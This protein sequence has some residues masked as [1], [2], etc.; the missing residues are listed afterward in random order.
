MADTVDRYQNGRRYLEKYGLVDDKVT[1]LNLFLQGHRVG[2]KG[3]HEIATGLIDNFSLTSLELRKQEIGKEGAVSIA[4]AL[5]QNRYLRYLGLGRNRIQS[6]GCIILMQ[7][8]CRNQAL[9][10]L[11]L[12]WNDIRDDG[13]IAIGEMLQTNNVLQSFILERNKIKAKGAQHIANGLK[14]NHKLM[15]LNLGYNKVTTSGAAALAG[16]LRENEHL[17]SLNLYMNDIRQEGGVAIAEAVRWNPGL[18]SLNLQGNPLE[19]AAVTF[20]SVLKYNSTL[21]ELNFQ[22][23]GLDTD[24]C[25]QMSEGLLNNQT[26]MSL[27]VAGNPIRNRGFKALLAALKGKTSLRFV[28]LSECGLEGLEAAEDLCELVDLGVNLQVLQLADNKLCREGIMLLCTRMERALA[29]HSLNLDR[30]NMQREGAIALAMA[31][32]QKNYWLSLSVVGNR[33]GVDATKKLLGPLASLTTLTELD[34][35]DNDVTNACNDS[36]SRVLK[37]NRNLNFVRVK[38]NPIAREVPN[39][40]FTQDMAY[41]WVNL[42]NLPESGALPFADGTPADAKPAPFLPAVSSPTSSP[43]ARTTF[44][45]PPGSPAVHVSNVSQD[46]GFGTFPS[47]TARIA[48]I[49]GFPVSSPAASR[50]GPPAVAAT[51]S[52]TAVG[53]GWAVTAKSPF[54]LSSPGPSLAPGLSPLSFTGSL[55]PSRTVYETSGLA[56]IEGNI[57]GLLITE[58]QLRRKFNELDVNGNGWLDVREFKFHFQRMENFGVHW[59]EA[60]VDALLSKHSLWKDGRMS[61]EEFCIV[62][63]GVARR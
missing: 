35:S 31:L 2:P 12:E 48:T 50:S 27:T 45:A 60:E 28:D 57:G 29:M 13:G 24:S 11:D 10:F 47:S 61:F 18:Q 7:G 4:Q 22:N 3:I 16:A 23:I 36:I 14:R 54:A 59:D 41:H 1:S 53:A 15:H 56:H 5:E 32:Q 8:L 40:I 19:G 26:L 30:T 46:F 39:G 25:I 43:P 38:D 6:E 34:I 37:S 42:P 52:P 44:K 49:T 9:Q 51:F 17:L 20:G 63:L 62:M 58:N 21:R 55:A 33:M